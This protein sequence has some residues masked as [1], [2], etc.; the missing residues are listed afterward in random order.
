M[1]ELVE[2][3]APF[4]RALDELDAQAGHMT[5]AAASLGIPQSSMSRRIHALERELGMELVV[6]E[7]RTVAMTPRARELAT[8]M[9]PILRELAGVLA[10]TVS[11]A[12][13][14][15]GTV[16][17]GY[18]LTLGAGSMPEI[19]AAFR[20]RHP[21]VHLHLKQAHGQA[22]VDDLQSGELDLAVVIPP[23]E[24]LPHRLIG[25]QSIVI[26]VPDDH[27]LAHHQRLRISALSAETFIANPPSY[28]LRRMTEETCR[29]AGFEPQVAI[30]ITEFSSIVELVSRGLGI[31][32]LPRGMAG[33][34]MVEIA[35]I[36]RIKRDIAL[37]VGAAGETAVTTTLHDFLREALR[38]TPL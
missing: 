8:R 14:D 22:L 18:P 30:E 13:A 7:G 5:R 10:D 35:P 19:L 9:R 24:K 4:L 33:A 21:G 15:T 1:D 34:G 29:A 32:L 11:A 31:S 17:F 20:R 16:R 27:R 25:R 28:H 12:D 38:S 2:A 26:V 3:L 36:G 23:P 6:R 37:V